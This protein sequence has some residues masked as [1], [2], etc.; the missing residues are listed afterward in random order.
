M[1][2]KARVFKIISCLLTIIILSQSCTIYRSSNLSVDEATDANNKVRVKT[3]LDQKYIFKRIGKDEKGIY[4]MAPKNSK[5]ARQLVNNIRQEDSSDGLVKI[6]LQE[7]M[8]D[9]INAQNKTLSILV[10]LL[11]VAAGVLTFA[12]TYEANASPFGESGSF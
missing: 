3:N 9:E 8:I 2:T 4:G 11:V 12:L 6:E 7:N 1:K 5:A 10:P